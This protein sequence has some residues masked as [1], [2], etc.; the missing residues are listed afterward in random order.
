MARSM[1]SFGT[2]WPLALATASARV[3]LPAMSPPPVRA[4]T[5]MVLISFAKS[6]LR[7]AS[8]TA[9]LCLVVAHLEWPLM[10]SPGLPA[11]SAHFE[12]Q[13]VH[14]GVPRQLRVKRRRQ[15]TGIPNGD[16]T[17]SDLCEHLHILSGTFDNGRPDENRVHRPTRDPGHLDLCLERVDL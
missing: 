7:L 4:A 16:A 12:K 8:T 3:G 1:L 14:A 13:R 2:D 15:P 17:A 9:F 11:F 10:N 6:L 5:S